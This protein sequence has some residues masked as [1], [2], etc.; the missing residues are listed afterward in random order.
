MKYPNVQL[1][2]GG[3]KQHIKDKQQVQDTLI[4]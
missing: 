3:K 2:E 4:A 1:L